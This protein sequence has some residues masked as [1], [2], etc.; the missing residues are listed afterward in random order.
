ME[1]RVE[2]CA[3]A[4]VGPQ[5]MFACLICDYDALSH[6]P[7]RYMIC[8]CCGTEFEND[9]EEATHAELRARWIAGGMKWWSRNTLPPEDWDP[10]RVRAGH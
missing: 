1:R 2:A 6:P 3:A 8:P 9:D 7:E 10:P 5:P 4:V